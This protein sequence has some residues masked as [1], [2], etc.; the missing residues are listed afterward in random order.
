MSESSRAA[1]V[2]ATEHF[3]RG[4]LAE[5]AAQCAAA[6]SMRP[7]DFDALHLM[8]VVAGQQGR[9]AE[10]ARW[11]GEAVAA[12]PRSVQALWN[13]GITQEKSGALE[14][15]AATYRAAIA[16][17]PDFAAA[18]A[19]LGNM[20][21]ALKRYDEAVAA[22]GTAM[23]LQPG[24]AKAASM[25]ACLLR[26]MCDWSDIRRI[27]DAL[28]ADVRAN[29]LAVLPFQFL[30]IADEPAL[31]LQCARQHWA[32]RKLAVAAPMPARR[33]EG[34]LRL[35]Y[36]SADFR[37]H[38]TSFLMAELFELHDRAQFE[39]LGFS[40]GR[41]EDSAMRRRLERAFDCF[42]DVESSSDEEIAA[43]VRTAGIDIAIDLK[44]LTQDGRLGILALRPAPVQVHYIG[45]PGTLGVDFIDYLVADAF[46]VPAEQERHFSEKI[47]RLPGAYQVNDRHRP[48]ARTPTRA[49]CGLPDGAFVFCCFNASYKFTPELFDVWIRIVKAAPGSVLW[50]LGDNRWAVANLKREAAARGLDPARLV[51]APRQALAEHLA[52]HR[53][54][55]LFLDTLPVNAHT[56]ASDAL[57]VGLPVLTCAGNSFSARV[58][59]SLLRAVGLGELIVETMADYERQAI[60]LAT[61]PAQMADLRAKLSRNL[62]SAPLFDAGRTT[63]HI[64]AA[65]RTMWEIHQ[66][67]EPPRSFSVD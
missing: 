63:R 36:L 16:L 66:R 51:F 41:Q 14:A 59:G 23:R 12:N 54:A 48:V 24:N 61:S 53:L 7:G 33:Q 22:L 2:L 43:R 4:R 6:L 30:A 50:L 39:V 34:R 10:S 46:V 35:A 42:V 13:L 52:R 17:K 40:Y 21:M 25:H 8:G 56:T 1:L 27:E 49:E 47:A 57:W 9:L 58:A 20:L 28:I 19:G 3:N 32:S 45:Y 29:R 55:D 62:P 31:Q 11:L 67:G 38:A 65:Y 5:A 64:E 37:D 26:V 44:G 18:H 15:A 60:R